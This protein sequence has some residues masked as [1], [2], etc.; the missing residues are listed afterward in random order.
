MGVGGWRNDFQEHCA[1]ILIEPFRSGVDVIVCSSI[2]TANNLGRMQVSLT[3]TC[4]YASRKA[5]TITVMS[6]LYTQ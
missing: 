2:W 1:F 5:L 4:S 6:S 3:N